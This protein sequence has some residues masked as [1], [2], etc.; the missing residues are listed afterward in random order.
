MSK[1]K[2]KNAKSNSKTKKPQSPKKRVGSKKNGISENL[3]ID[4]QKEKE[5]YLRLFAEFENFKKR[6]SRERLEL[7]KSANK[8][9][10]SAFPRFLNK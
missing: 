8:E 9:V 10:M 5:K 2:D 4:L 1:T 7:F 3:K 6:T